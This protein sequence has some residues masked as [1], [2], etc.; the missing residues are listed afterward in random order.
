MNF[1]RI[2]SLIYLTLIAF[3]CGSCQTTDKTSSDQPSSFQ[4]GVA[5]GDPLQDRVIIWTRLNPPKNADTLALDWEMSESED[6]SSPVAS[7]QVETN[8]GRDFTVKVDVNG[9]DAGRQYFYRFGL[10][11]QYSPIGRTKT[12]TKDAD[13]LRLAIVSCSN[14]EWGYFN[15]YRHIAGKEAIDAVLHL[16]DYIYEYAPGGYGDTTLGRKHHPPKELIS[17]EDY[18]ARYAQYRSDADLQ[19][20]HRNHPF[21]AIWDDHEIAND[22]YVSGAQNH[23]EDEGDFIERKNAAVKAYYEWMPVREDSQLYRRFDFGSLADVI[24]LDERLEGRS[25]PAEH[26]D[27]PK[28]NTAAHSML[29]DEQ[30]SWLKDQLSSSEA[31][32]KVIGN[33]VIFSDLDRSLVFPKSPRNL[34]S[35]DG[36]PLERN[37]I[38][39]YIL[40][41]Q[42]ENVIFTTGD[43]HASWA[44]DVTISEISAEPI[45]TEFGTPSVNSANYDEYTNLDTAKMAE[46]FYQEANP[47]LRYSNLS[48]HGYVLL[49]LTTEKATARYYHMTTVKLPDADEVLARRLEVASGSPGIVE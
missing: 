7:G 25:Q 34:D 8:S 5:S 37:E 28:L 35:W 6:F 44:L 22:A 23:Q 46:G 9:L 3:I 39:R 16:G 1:S 47:H 30:L 15:A 19:A 14:Y 32:W 48:E 45:A 38:A 2:Y 24:M 26:I 41:E 21:I 12:A 13:S 36:Y 29:G 42:I 40:N 11:S 10:G 17:L 33:Q 31:Q 4:Y 18:R 20:V 43:T 27:D 49:T